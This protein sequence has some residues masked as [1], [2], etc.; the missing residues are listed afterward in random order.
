MLK[1]N[2][3]EIYLSYYELGVEFPPAPHHI[4]HIDTQFAPFME[5]IILSQLLMCHLYHSKMIKLIYMSLLMS[6]KHI[7]VYFWSLCS[8]SLVYLFILMPVSHYLNSSAILCL[9]VTDCPHCPSTF[10][11]HPL[12]HLRYDWQY[13]F[14]SV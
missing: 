13:N 7:W 6:L 2:L 10:C 9:R 12:F 1:Y 5:K 14:V 11:T 3:S 8:L 4:V